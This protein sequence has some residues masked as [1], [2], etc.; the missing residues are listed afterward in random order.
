M[1]IRIAAGCSTDKKFKHLI[2]A[3]FQLGEGL[4]LFYE[5]KKKAAESCTFIAPYFLRYRQTVF[6]PYVPVL[7]L[8]PPAM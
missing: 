6:H 5:S 4:V 2:G 8:S 1:L 7:T 3:S